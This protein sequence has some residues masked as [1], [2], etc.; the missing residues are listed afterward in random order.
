MYSINNVM[1]HHIHDNICQ[2]CMK[3]FNRSHGVNH[4][5]FCW[6][7]KAWNTLI[8]KSLAIDRFKLNGRSTC[9]WRGLEKYTFILP[10]NDLIIGHI[11][12]DVEMHTVKSLYES[13]QKTDKPG[14]KRRVDRLNA[15][16]E[17][18][19]LERDQ[20]IY[21]VKYMVNFIEY[22]FARRRLTDD[23]YANFKKFILNQNQANMRNE[24]VVYA[25]SM[26]VVQ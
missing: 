26:C 2:L 11:V 10:F 4:D 20:R 3:E 19:A 23:D 7:S 21:Q 13:I 5:K 24:A 22:A 6:S 15:V 8:T 25:A 1:D 16:W 18:C 12:D 9:T 17:S 14:L